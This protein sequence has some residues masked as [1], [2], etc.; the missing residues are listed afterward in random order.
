MLKFRLEKAQQ[1][2]EEAEI[3]EHLETQYLSNMVHSS[4]KLF[5]VKSKYLNFLH[6]PRDSRDHK[7][8]S[9]NSSLQRPADRSST[10]KKSTSLTFM[11]QINKRS[12][13][14]K[15]DVS[16]G[17]HLHKDA[18]ARLKSKLMSQNS[19]NSQREISRSPVRDTDRLTGKYLWKKVRVELQKII[20]KYS[21]RNPLTSQEMGV[22]L[23]ELGYLKKIGQRV[24][25]N[26]KIVDLPSQIVKILKL[27]RK[28]AKEVYHIEGANVT[29]IELTKEFLKHLCIPNRVSTRYGW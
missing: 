24:K 23:V 6:S 17:D 20:T 9:L 16:I 13:L 8:S 1:R 26:G 3:H 27:D 5:K 19:Q 15:R 29:T 14:L 28:V 7:E 10:L 21:M 18:S 11:P 4:S 2:A 12:K 22:I 25:V